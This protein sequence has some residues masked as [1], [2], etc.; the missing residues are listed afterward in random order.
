[1]AEKVV[2][3]KKFKETA[4]GLN[5]AYQTS[6]I[7]FALLQKKHENVFHQI[8]PRVKCRDYLNDCIAFGQAGKAFESYGLKFDPN[9]FKPNLSKPLH[10]ELYWSKQEEEKAFLNQVELLQ[11]YEYSIGIN[12][13][14]VTSID[15]N[16]VIIE[17]DPFWQSN[18]V[19]YSLYTWLLRLLSYPI[20]TKP[21]HL[22]GYID[23]VISYLKSKRADE[24]SFLVKIQPKVWDVVLPN[25]RDLKLK[26]WAGF[27]VVGRN[28]KKI[29]NFGGFYSVFNSGSRLFNASGNSWLS[30]SDHSAHIEEVKQLFK[31]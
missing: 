10:F 31:F 24:Y 8:T 15:K 19:V 3:I 13:S 27:E 26:E 16:T 18:Q 12:R 29:H 7:R 1:M 9:D 5:E 25:L 4:D 23:E 22:R 2:L 14:V 20:E 28:T 6:G 11:Q 17:A 30:E 21:T